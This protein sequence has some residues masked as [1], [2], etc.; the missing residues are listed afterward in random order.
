MAVARAAPA[1]ELRLVLVILT[2]LSYLG[3]AVDLL[4]QQQTRH[5]VRKGKRAQA[6]QSGPIRLECWRETLST[7]DEEAQSA[8]ALFQAGE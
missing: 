5:L 6:E 3:C 7:A 1:Q 8:S 4:D 2:P